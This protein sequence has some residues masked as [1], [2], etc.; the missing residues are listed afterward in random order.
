MLVVVTYDVSTKTREGR[1]RLRKISEHCSDWGRRVQ[2]SVFELHVDPGQW[3]KL[4]HN[5]LE[6]FNV[7]EDSLRF[8][9]LGSNWERKV[10]RH[11]VKKN[12]D[13]DEFHVI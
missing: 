6:E 4:K 1:K 11:G 5:L 13:I 2:F 8:Y 7:K 10:E 12:L 9:Y 3:E